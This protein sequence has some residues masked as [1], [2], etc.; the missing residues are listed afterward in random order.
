[1]FS[2]YLA[3]D[4][5]QYGNITTLQTD[6][7]GECVCLLQGIPE[8]NDTTSCDYYVMRYMRDIVL[9]TELAFADKVT[10]IFHFQLHCLQV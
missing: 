5:Y 3:F 10:K 7:C 8:Q 6:A 4:N 2:I 9:D 1:M